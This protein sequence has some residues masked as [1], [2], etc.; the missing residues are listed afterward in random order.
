MSE[1]THTILKYLFQDNNFHQL[2]TLAWNLY[3]TY[4]APARQPRTGQKSANM[5]PATLEQMRQRL[6][7]EHH[8]LSRRLKEVSHYIAANPQSIAI[9]TAAVV[10]DKAGVHASTLVRFANHFEFNGFTELQKLYKEHLHQNYQTHGDY[11]ARIRAL[12]HN[13]EHPVTPE[14]LHNEFTEANILSLQQG[15]DRIDPQL[16]SNAVELMHAASTIHVCGVRRAFPVSMVFAYALGHLQ[17]NCQAITG[18]GLMHDDQLRNI[19]SGDVLIAITFS[20]YAKATQSMIKTATEK[21]AQIILIADDNH[22]PSA[23]L[24]DIFFPVQDAEVRSFRSLTSTM[25]LAQTLCIALGYRR[26]Q[27]TH[28]QTD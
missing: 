20:P 10:A 16:L 18:I 3:F 27:R 9:D 2:S 24:A 11:G 17:V 26:D 5:Q 15:R 19:K 7:T 21:N 12:Q 22:C 14:Q 6:T 4:Y 23:A 25:C 13:D 1:S 28:Q 8:T